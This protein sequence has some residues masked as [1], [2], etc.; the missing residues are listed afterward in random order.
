MFFSLVFKIQIR[1]ITIRKSRRLGTV[2]DLL[3]ST[4]CSTCKRLL[5]SVPKSFAGKTQCVFLSQLTLILPL[6]NICLELVLAEAK[7]WRTRQAQW[8]ALHESLACSFSETVS[9]LLP[10]SKGIRIHRK[11][12]LRDVNECM[13]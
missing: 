1:N 12:P 13:H 10:E 9:N 2:E 11:K 8:Q 7:F 5:A 4:S 6:S 3:R